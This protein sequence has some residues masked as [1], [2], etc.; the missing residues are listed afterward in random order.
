LAT[1]IV[2]AD[3]PHDCPDI[4]ALLSAQDS[5]Q[6]LQDHI[7][8]LHVMD[9][10]AASALLEKA[11]PN[12]EIFCRFAAPAI[13]CNRDALRNKSRQKPNVL[14][15]RC[16]NGGLAKPSSKHEFYMEPGQ[17]EELSLSPAYIR[18]DSATLTNPQLAEPYLLAVISHKQG[19]F[20]TPFSSMC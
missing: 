5:D 10:I 1:S 17:A 6:L 2:R 13:R 7:K 15:A 9:N 8:Y 4:C 18:P 3:C 14:N 20:G 19:T 11:N 16:A 12:N